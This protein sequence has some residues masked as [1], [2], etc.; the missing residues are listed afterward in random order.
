MDTLIGSTATAATLLGFRAASVVNQYLRLRWRARLEHARR[1]YLETA[2]RTL[3]AGSR[4]EDEVSADGSRFRLSVASPRS[5]AD[6]P[7]D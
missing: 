4:L 3:P 1:H 5:R 6:L 7:L 2:A